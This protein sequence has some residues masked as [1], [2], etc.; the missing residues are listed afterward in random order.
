VAITPSFEKLLQFET[1]K[2]TV[3][4]AFLIFA[5]AIAAQGDH[6]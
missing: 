2:G 4:G 5:N 3:S 6:G 1:M